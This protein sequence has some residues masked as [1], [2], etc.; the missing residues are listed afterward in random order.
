[1]A[2]ET[3]PYRRV[4]DDLRRRIAEG[5]LQPGDRLPGRDGLAEQYDVSP[6][7]I[8]RALRI[9]ANEGVVKGRS[10]DGT[11]V[12]E[13][14]KLTDL[15][16]HPRNE[17]PDSPWRTGA[18]DVGAVGAWTSTSSTTTA[19]ADIAERL[20]IEP[21]DRVMCTSYLFTADGEPSMLSNSW[22]PLAITGGE[23]IL[24]PEDG[25]LAGAGVVARMT[26]IGITVVEAEE[27]S[28]ARPATPREA[29]QLGEPVGA[30]L[31][32]IERTYRDD[33]GRPVE[34]A[35]ILIPVARYSLVYRLPVE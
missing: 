31:M 13:R 28:S 19:P 23:P 22:E 5:A 24:L 10:G 8:V 17:Q 20:D 35:D 18:A 27:R 33:T 25:P 1:M 6:S 30:L 4:A 16:R 26:S 15:V 2:R 3:P 21:G 32:T 11:Y 14:P 29:E 9:L 12:R 34:T 7:S